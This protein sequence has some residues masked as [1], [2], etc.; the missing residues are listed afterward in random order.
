[1]GVG[2]VP[3]TRPG[4]SGPGP[5]ADAFAEHGRP[6]YQSVS[7][8]RSAND[9]GEGGFGSSPSMDADLGVDFPELSDRIFAELAADRD[10]EQYAG[11]GAALIV[12]VGRLLRL[13]RHSPMGS[14][15][16]G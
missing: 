10:L 6:P 15:P 1:M 16:L 14:R 11:R 12:S 7:R 2:R 4:R 9:G 3:E 13:V 5:L 8:A